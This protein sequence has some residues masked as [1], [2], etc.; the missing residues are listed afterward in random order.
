[1]ITIEVIIEGRADFSQQTWFDYCSTTLITNS[2]GKYILCDPGSNRDLLLK[3]LHERNINID[4]I[5]YIF[6]CVD[7]YILN[8]AHT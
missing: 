7:C 8:V 4:D 6:I 2:N 5:H 3:K 1:M